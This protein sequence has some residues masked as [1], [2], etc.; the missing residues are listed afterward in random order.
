[1]HSLKIERSVEV[2]IRLSSD[3]MNVVIAG[4][5]EKT[6]IFSLVFVVGRSRIHFS[7]FAFNFQSFFVWCVC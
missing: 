2:V 1:M 7:G 3:S 6:R 5:D 4:R